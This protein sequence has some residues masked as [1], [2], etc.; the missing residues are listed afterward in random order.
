MIWMAWVTSVFQLRVVGWKSLD[1]V[2]YFK[3]NKEKKRVINY[4]IL[5]QHIIFIKD[6]WTYNELLKQLKNIPTIIN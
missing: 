6:K 3:G 1:I 4:C 5:I 2:S